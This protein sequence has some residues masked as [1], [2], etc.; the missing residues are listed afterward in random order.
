MREERIEAADC[1][2]TV[3]LGTAAVAMVAVTGGDLVACPEHNDTCKG[4][5]T[6]HSHHHG[7]KAQRYY[8][9]HDR[10]SNL[11]IPVS[12]SCVLAIGEGDTYID[13]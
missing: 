8:R 12:M 3:C 7:N 4:I 13:Y 9:V 6:F 5:I 1:F 11:C 2:W 10:M